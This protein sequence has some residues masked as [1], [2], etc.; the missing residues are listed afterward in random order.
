MAIL[1]PALVEEWELSPAEADYIDR[2]QG[3]HCSS[4]GA[5][6]RSMA[7][8]RAILD[9]AGF[10]G[11]LSAFVSSG[12]AGLRVLEINKAGQLTQF[13]GQLPGHKLVEFP[14]VDMQA[15]PFEDGSF[16]LIVHSDTLEHV[17]DPV[18]GLQEC[19]RVSA[20][21]GATCFTIPIVVGRLTRDRHDL[22][23]SYHGAGDEPNLVRTEYGADAWC[24]LFLAGFT[25]CRVTC[26]E[27]PSGLAITALSRGSG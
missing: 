22:A 11:T 23:P 21:S 25:E 1:W 2:Q 9:H 26:I 24:Q 4:C 20:P 27:Y 8:A 18:K 3:Y 7:L 15:L 16:D 19:R 10:T 6:L 5:N 14:E 17:P 12:R 13:L